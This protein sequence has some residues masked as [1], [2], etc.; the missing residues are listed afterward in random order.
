MRWREDDGGRVVDREGEERERPEEGMGLPCAWVGI[1][2]QGE[3]E[4]AHGNHLKGI[5]GQ[6]VGVLTSQS[7]ATKWC[8][9]LC[10]ALKMLCDI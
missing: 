1:E 9:P 6:S 3:N 4:A 2:G 10:S 8:A 7:F 5:I